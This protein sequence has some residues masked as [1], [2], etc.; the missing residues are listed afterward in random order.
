[1]IHLTMERRMRPLIKRMVVPGLLVAGLLWGLL[2]PPAAAGQAEQTATPTLVASATTS[3][4]PSASATVVSTA[5]AAPSATPTSSATAN[6]SATVLTSASP[7]LTLT[8]TATATVTVAMPMANSPIANVPFATKGSI[9][10]K[11]AI[12]ST[13]GNPFTELAAG[14]SHTCGLVS[15]G[16]AYCWG[17][18]SYGQLGDGTVG[19]QT[20]PVAV[21]S[22]RSYTM[23]VA[24]YSHTCGLGSGGT[25]YCWGANFRGQ[26]GNGTTGQQTA[27]VA[28]SGERTFASLVA[29]YHHSCGL[30]AAGT[31][32]CWGSNDSGQLG[33]GTSG[34]N[35][36]GSAN[37][38]VPVA[39]SGGRAF[40]NLA[41]GGSHTCGLVSD[42]TAYCWGGQSTTVPEEVAG[43]WTYT[44]LVAGG[45][46]TCGLV[47]GGVPYCWGNNA[48]GQL[49]DGTSGTTGSVPTL[50]AGGLSFSR[51]VAG[52]NF[53]CGLASNRAVYCWGRNGQGQLGDG[54][55]GTNR[56]V[57]TLVT[58]SA[59]GLEAM[60]R[61]IGFT[62]EWRGIAA[63]QGLIHF[64]DP[65]AQAVF[66][67]GQFGERLAGPRAWRIQWRTWAGSIATAARPISWR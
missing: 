12:N 44:S 17:G 31:A 1:M 24:G 33:D 4:T 56:S 22:G 21:S 34:V 62:L 49:G 9:G 42:G 27:P 61:G 58:A 35:W 10:P 7:T 32:Y 5:S 54:T 20:A 15:S 65:A 3:A 63:S 55:S 48:Y 28:V 66:G 14:W 57:P 41:A 46:H 18:N 50:V 53:T 23:I 8:R 16:T 40:T 30:T 25:A 60:W 59:R 64:R 26:I 19:Q 51:L 2:P 29:G 67:R 45:N 11:V 43:G 39:V 52:E 37:R 36:D 47:S 6:P 13:T 38:M